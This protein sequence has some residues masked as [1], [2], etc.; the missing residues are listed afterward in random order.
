MRTRRTYM[1]M[2]R[3]FGHVTKEQQQALQRLAMNI[4]KQK[5]CGF[6]HLQPLLSGNICTRA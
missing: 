5:Y 3:L 1:V 2:F 4:R 6:E